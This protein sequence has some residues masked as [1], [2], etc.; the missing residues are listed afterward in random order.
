MSSTPAG[1]RWSI[2][3]D[4]HGPGHAAGVPQWVSNYSFIEYFERLG[5]TSCVASGKSLSLSGPSILMCKG[6][7][8]M[9]PLLLAV[10][11]G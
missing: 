11:E 8:I 7:V 2:S 9:L 6:G 1:P 5:G 4:Q 10:Y 3:V